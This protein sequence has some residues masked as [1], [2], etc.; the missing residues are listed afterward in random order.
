VAWTLINVGGITMVLDV[1]TPANRGQLIGV[2]N[3]W[4]LAGLAMGPLVGSFLVDLMGFSLGMLICAIITAIGLVIALAL[5]PVTAP[6][7]GDRAGPERQPGVKVGLWLRDAWHTGLG[8]W[9]AGGRGL[10]TAAWLYLIVMFAGDGV[11]LSTVSLLLQERF[12]RTV[13]LDS[14]TLGVASA[15][16]L[17][18]ATRYLLAGVIG[19]LAGHLS[20]AYL[21]RWPVIAGGLMVGAVGFGLLSLASSSW[22]IVLGVLLGAVSAGAT[23]AA[24][25]A[26]VGD[27]APAGSEGAVMGA[28]ATAGD[29]G[30]MAGPFVA[31]ALA[32]SVGLRWVYALCTLAFLLGLALVWCGVRGT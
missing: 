20:D 2:Y 24:L 31:F 23:L 32:A 30:S 29:M 7:A 17:L 1:S 18:L 8:S 19:P 22:G 14:L 9:L 11:I 28:Y 27:R 26:H 15:A 21:G 25:T 5:V 12:G 10:V 6:Q 4:V 16:G 13:A 3:T